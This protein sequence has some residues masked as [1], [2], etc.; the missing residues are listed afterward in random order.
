[1]PI[2][3]MTAKQYAEFRGVS[4]PYVNEI[5]RR[6]DEWRNHSDKLVRLS[7]ANAKSKSWTK[8]KHKEAIEQLKKAGYGPEVSE[9]DI[10]KFGNQR[11]LT[12]TYNS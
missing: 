4:Y 8:L 7:D 10:Q 3:Q 1:M 5:L 2:K 12:V 6:I 9:I 11:L